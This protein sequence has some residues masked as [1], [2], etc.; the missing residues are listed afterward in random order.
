MKHNIMNANIM[1]RDRREQRENF[2]APESLVRRGGDRRRYPRGFG[3]GAFGGR[4]PERF[5]GRMPK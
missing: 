2:M 1:I 3:G 5:E 4:W